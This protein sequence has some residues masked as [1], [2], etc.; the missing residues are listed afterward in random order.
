MKKVLELFKF[1]STFEIWSSK[2]VKNI[3][4][5]KS[6]YFYFLTLFFSGLSKILKPEKLLNYKISVQKK[7]C[8]TPAI[9]LGNSTLQLGK[10]VLIKASYKIKC[11]V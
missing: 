3:L 5:S 8:K 7:L 10:V 6:I 9:T 1:I 4:L 2:R 11:M